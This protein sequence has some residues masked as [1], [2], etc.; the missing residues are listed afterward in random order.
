MLLWHKCNS[1]PLL[2]YSPPPQTL[3]SVYWCWKMPNFRKA[4]YTYICVYI[5]LIIIFPL[6]LQSVTE[7]ISMTSSHLSMS[8]ISE[9]ETTK[10]NKN[11]SQQRK[12][13]PNMLEDHRKQGQPRPNYEKS[14]PRRSSQLLALVLFRAA[15]LWAS[16][17]Y[18]KAWSVTASF[19]FGQCPELQSKARSKS[20]WAR[21]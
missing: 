13:K 6:D 17:L 21:Q 14:Q 19:E 1:F 2:F 8:G 4:I 9:V 16:C 20:E 12:Q 10:K 18:H 15:I 7:T 5:F 11:I 3:L